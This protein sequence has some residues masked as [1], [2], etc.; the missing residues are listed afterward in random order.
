[1]T[2]VMPESFHLGRAPDVLFPLRLDTEIAPQHLNFLPTIVRLR[3][4]MNLVQAR[5][6]IDAIWPDYKKTDTNLKT[7][8]LTPYKDFLVG[9]SRPVL[10]VLLGA[11]AAVL[12]IACTNTANLLLARAA[13][14]EKEIVIRISLGCGRMRLARQLLAESLT[15]AMVGGTMGVLLAWASLGGLT[16]LLARQLPREVTVHLDYR[17][18]V[19]AAGISLLTGIAFG[20]VPALQVL[21]SNKADGRQV[22]QV[23]GAGCAMVWWSWSSLFLWCCW[24][25]RDC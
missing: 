8:W 14:R 18:L 16:S 23:A 20:L 7:V 1:V 13:G 2:G 6:A 12:L 17:V 19:F 24:L 3:K 10:L 11:V 15:L 5:A 9:D 4:G 25:W 22:V 21:A